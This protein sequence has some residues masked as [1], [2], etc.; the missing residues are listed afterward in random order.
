VET[1]LGRRLYL[2]EINSRNGQRRQYA[3]R[4]AINA[5]M[6]GT[7]ADIIKLAMIDVDKWLQGDAGEQVR[8]IMQ[9]HDELVFEVHESYLESATDEIRT[10]MQRAA[11]LCVPLVVDIGTGKN[12]EAAH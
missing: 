8:M 7:A 6:Q 11:E 4:T 12:W 5:P 1:V 3:E 2:P 9:V 10:R